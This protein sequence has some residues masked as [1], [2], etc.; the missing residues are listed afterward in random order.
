MNYSQTSLVL[1]APAKLNL[2]LHITG[3]RNDGYHNLETLF[4]FIDIEDTLSFES[5]AGHEVELI[6][7]Q[8]AINVQDNL[9]FRAAQRLINQ[10]QQHQVSYFGVRIT[11]EKRLPQG[12]GL[13]GGSSDAATT[14]VGL[15]YLWGQPFTKQQLLTIGAELGADVPI[16]I[17]GHSAF[18]T[19][20]GDQ[21]TDVEPDQSYYLVV[22][23]Q[24]NISTAAL[25]ADAGLKRD[26]KPLSPSQWDWQNTN[27]VF[28]SV[29][30]KQYPAVAKLHAQLLNYGPTRL[31]GTGACLFTRFANQQQA[32][33]AQAQLSLPES[34]VV[35]GQ[36]RSSLI[37][38]LTQI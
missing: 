30:L 10:C 1:P 3:K 31:T 34:Y 25:F 35:R 15:N 16:F 8:S 9:V 36:N 13:G 24:V 14:L 23:P 6:D 26:C 22:K 2:F 37:R 7:T 21:F 38:T 4:Q 32:I 11:L 29:V 20:I 18:A 33:A 28:E 27:N 19:G 5:V 12:A 17:H